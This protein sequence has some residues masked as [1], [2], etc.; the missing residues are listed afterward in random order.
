MV[1]KFLVLFFLMMASFSFAQ[2]P[3]GSW[4]LFTPNNSPRDIVSNEKKVFVA[5]Q[6]GLLEYDVESG[7]KDLWTAANYL[8]DIN[9]TALCYAPVSNT[10]LVGYANGNIDLI[11]NNVLF[12]LPALAIANVF[13][14]KRI[15]KMVYHEGFVYVATGIGILKVNPE[16][17]EVADTYYPFSSA[18]T[19]KDV[20][21]VGNTIYAL[22][23][24]T[25][26]YANANSPALADFTQWQTL[27]GVPQNTGGEFVNLINFQNELFLSFKTPYI[28]Y[29]TDTIYKRVNDVFEVQSEFNNKEIYKLHV[30]QNKL[31]VSMDLL[32]QVFDENMD[33]VEQIYQYN[34][35][36]AIR[37]NAALIIGV[38]HYIADDKFGLV[39]ARNSF[40]HEKI[41]FEGPFR[42]SFF[43][44]D[45]KKGK[46]LVAGGGLAGNNPS[47]NTS[48][49]YMFEDEKWNYLHGTNAPLM[50]QN[51]FDCISVSIDPNDL[52]HF[53]IGT[54]SQR[55]LFEVRD[56]KTIDAFYDGSNSNLELATLN[57]GT[58]NVAKLFFDDNSNLWISQSFSTA[59]L[60]VKTKDGLFLSMNMGVQ[61]NAKIIK[62]LSIDFN[63][64][65]WVASRGGGLTVFNDNGTLLDP[66]DDEFRHFGT[67]EG[68]GNLPS[69]EVRA[70][71]VDFNNDI[72]I[73]TDKGLRI[74]YN[75][76]RVFNNAQ[77]PD[78]QP[79]LIEFEEEIE[80]V[81]GDAAITKI[82]VDG[83]NRKW[84]ATESSGVILFESDGRNE[85]Y[86]FNTTN[87]PLISDF[88]LDI[89]INE[90]TGEVFFVTENGLQSFRSDASKSDFDYKDVH[91]FP[92][93]YRP[94]FTGVVT[95]QGIVFNSEVNIT[96]VAGNVV[97][98]TVSNGGTATWNGQTLRGEK[99]ASGVYQI[100]TANVSGKGR[101]VGKFVLIN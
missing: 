15:N 99:A 67:S 13:G 17:R 34:E 88:V 48:G 43:A 35:G 76:S 70:V 16:R 45:N 81:L 101:Y 19:I 100:W 82:V 4:R 62:D 6:N 74:L 91:V 69:S 25:I 7:E 39:K 89:A 22:S 32:L 23:N 40:L 54:F 50:A 63:G 44:L 14:D 31:L 3:M 58:Y 71:A 8:S 78:A 49:V 75:S 57:N 9:L 30:D 84:V 77:V 55:P 90:N 10:V 27:S 92:N 56:G 33:I 86:N 24:S 38:E 29:A 52:N 64:Y 87:S 42:N 93:P 12:N 51:T 97:Y 1:M 79:I 95:I 96:D 59:P 18:Q 72:W 80:R 66:S 37:P 68:N 20:A 53:A 26:R 5:F 41:Q 36:E 65:K 60:K 46:L 11:E 28:T 94:D 2:L 85:V 73:G 98:K 21:F 61:H 47:N 83:G